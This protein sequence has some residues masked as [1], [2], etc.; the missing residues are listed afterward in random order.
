MRKKEDE[1]L[2]GTLNTH[3]NGL[4][5]WTYL[6]E[7]GD[8]AVQP[9]PPETDFTQALSTAYNTLKNRP[10]SRYRVFYAPASKHLTFI[11]TEDDMLPES[12]L[13]MGYSHNL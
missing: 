1:Y 4:G 2:I 10:C 8:P 9:T 7:P 6:P 11:P 5:E 12:P 13:D 3:S